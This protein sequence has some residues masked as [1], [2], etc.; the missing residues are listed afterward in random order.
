MQNTYRKDG[1]IHNFA[2]PH[3]ETLVSLKIT[4]NYWEQGPDTAIHDGYVYFKFTDENL[5][6]A[7]ETAVIAKV[8]Y[9]GPLTAAYFGV[10]SLSRNGQDDTKDEYREYQNFLTY[11]QERL[12]R[13]D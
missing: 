5:L 4:D 9:T 11:I 7:D 3:L 13:I 12:M 10:K 8:L 2:H 1:F 6:V